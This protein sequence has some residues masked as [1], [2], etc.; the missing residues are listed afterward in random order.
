MKLPT[1]A[2]VTSILATIVVAGQ[3]MAGS[4]TK[5]APTW[6]G[7]HS[8]IS[9][10]PPNYG[11]KKTTIT[12]TT[13]DASLKA[14]DSFNTN[15]S[16]NPSTEFIS[17]SQKVKTRKDIVNGDVLAAPTSANLIGPQQSAYQDGFFSVNVGNGGGV[18]KSGG[19]LFNR[20]EDNRMAI[21][22]VS[23]TLS[24]GG[25]NGGIMENKSQVLVNFDGEQ[26]V[27][28]VNRS[29]V[30]NDFGNKQTLLTGNQS[31][32]QQP[33]VV[34]NGDTTAIASDTTTSSASTK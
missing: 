22:S 13:I 3:A 21:T 19:G 14:V 6:K 8:T 27:D 28:G 29:V 18:S 33:N 15:G 12:K 30:G 4:P 5:P 20:S 16:F 24:T 25:N 7:Y 1:R 2:I 26:V 31:S 23:Q 17:A 34:K 11:Y 9:K 10:Y 32:S